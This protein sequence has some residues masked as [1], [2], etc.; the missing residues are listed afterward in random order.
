[1][2]KKRL[3]NTVFSNNATHKRCSNLFLGTIV[4]SKNSTVYNP[5][6]NVVD[7]VFYW[8]DSGVSSCVNCGLLNGNFSVNLP[9]QMIDFQIEMSNLFGNLTENLK[10]MFEF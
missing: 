5:S 10:N 3:K 1:M 4:D 2:H 8:S 6:G 9:Q 7:N